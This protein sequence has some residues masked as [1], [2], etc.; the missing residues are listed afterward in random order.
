M[1]G[2]YRSALK[3]RV[4]DEM[5][6]DTM[7]KRKSRGFTLIELLIVIAIIGVLAAIMTPVLVRARFKTYHAACV[8]NERNM[9]TA[10]E[11]Y[12]LE[13]EQLYPD[14]LDTIATG[15]DP[16]MKSIPECPSAGVNYSGTYTVD[17]DNRTYVVEC[18]GFH[19]IQL[20]GL[21]DATYPRITEN[22]V[23]V[24]NASE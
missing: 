10:L 20:T 1:S 3:V 9:A 8:Q 13:N 24:F 22:R 6:G 2:V 4:A 15:D 5:L 12:A 17:D 23:F 11:L 16:F 14:D 21:V 19:H 18:P 7:S